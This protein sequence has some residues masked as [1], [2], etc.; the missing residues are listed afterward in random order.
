MYV[1]RRSRSNDIRFH[2]VPQAAK[3]GLWERL[4]LG[5]VEVPEARKDGSELRKMAFAEAT[6]AV[7]WSQGFS[8]AWQRCGKLWLMDVYRMFIAD[9]TEYDSMLADVYMMC[10]N[11]IHPD[12]LK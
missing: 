11:Y 9:I 12:G 1:Y 4:G 8:F 7:A 6:E 5:P 2:D 3:S 10:T